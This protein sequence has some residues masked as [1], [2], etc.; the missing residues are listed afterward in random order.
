MPPA[1]PITPAD[2]TVVA[3]SAFTPGSTGPSVAI[4]TYDPKT[5]QFATPDG[6][7][8]RQADV[9]TGA[10]RRVWTDLLPIG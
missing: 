8:A 3:P 10:G 1:Q 2:G 5:G 9:M 6:T 7:V 4:A